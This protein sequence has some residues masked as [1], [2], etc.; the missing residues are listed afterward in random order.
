MRKIFCSFLVITCLFGVVT[1]LTTANTQFRL[2]DADKDGKITAADALTVL[3]IVVGRYNTEI[4]SETVS[5]STMQGSIV[6]KVAADVDGSGIV[7][8]TDAL[9]ILQYVVGK[10]DQFAGEAVVQSPTDIPVIPEGVAINAENFPDP[11]FRNDVTNFD[12]DKNGYLSEHEIEQV[13][14]IDVTRFR[15]GIPENGVAKREAILSLKGIEYFTELK[16]LR[17]GQ[18]NQLSFL[19]VSQNK[20]LE[21][22]YCRENLLTELNL[23]QNTALKELDCSSNNLERLNLSHLPNLFALSCSYNSIE[24]L[25]LSGNLELEELNCSGNQL[26]KL[27]L[28]KNTQLKIVICNKNNLDSLDVSKNTQLEYL[29]CTG[30]YITE[31]DLINNTALNTVLA[32]SNVILTGWQQK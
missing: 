21:I 19:D 18:G 20:M 12:I 16:D 9:E 29:W 25:D 8:A 7:S 31:L 15:D 28:S 11:V 1:L 5:D 32:D 6:D 26:G 10:R 13:T 27:E 30:N 23:E 14:Q 4:T 17:C 3:K 24:E 2:G 22:L